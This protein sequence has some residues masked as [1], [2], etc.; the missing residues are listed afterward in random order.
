MNSAMHE[1][2]QQTLVDAVN[3]LT[4]EQVPYALIGGL[5]VSLRGQP[6]MT[7]DV[8]MVIL[9]DVPRSLALVR[10]L[11]GSNFK[12]LF[13]GVAE[14]WSKRHSSFPSGIV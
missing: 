7:A 1:P 6:R 4:A 3:F 2:L 13:D 14:V 9:A 11:G 8:D 5:A 10:A 12:P